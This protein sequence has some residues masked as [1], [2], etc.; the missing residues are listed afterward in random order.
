MKTHTIIIIDRAD[1][2]RELADK[3]A[4]SRGFSVL[5]TSGDLT[6]IH[7][8]MKNKYTLWEYE[9]DGFSNADANAKSKGGLKV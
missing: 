4:A 9:K 2:G 3:I 8:D 7:Q 6:G 1:F 5:K